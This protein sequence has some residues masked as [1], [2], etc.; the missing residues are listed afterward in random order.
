MRFS[1]TTVYNRE[2]LADFNKFVAL[3][4]KWFWI[5]LSVCTV[6]T[7]SSFLLLL[8]LG[9]FDKTVLFG[10]LLVAFVDVFYLL[11]TFLVPKIVAKRSPA[12]NATISF[13]FHSDVFS[14]SAV[15]KTG[16]EAAE[17]RY[18]LIIKARETTDVIYLYIAKQQAYIV[19]KSTLQPG[20]LE[21]FRAFLKNR[22]I[23]IK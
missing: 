7:L 17:H 9:T 12:L 8:A 11:I 1:A 10:L 14:V 22:N 18:S 6:V 15:T 20:S 23:D 21:D 3:E 4:R 5:L 16:R 2:K 13:E 19:D